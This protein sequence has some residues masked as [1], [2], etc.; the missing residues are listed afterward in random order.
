MR[1]THSK[2]FGNICVDEA[3]AQHSV[4]SERLKKQ[5][6]FAEESHPGG[7][8]TGNKKDALSVFGILNQTKTA[9]GAALLKSTRCHC[10]SPLHPSSLPRYVWLM[11][12]RNIAQDMAAESFNKQ[13]GKLS[14]T[15]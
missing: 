3:T 15:I 13:E 4:H 14:L 9:K 6:I 11:L 10:H 5:S 12:T 7:S 2:R 8:G 1:W